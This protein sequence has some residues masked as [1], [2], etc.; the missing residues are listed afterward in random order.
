MSFT[1]EHV[2]AAGQA[3]R[4]H[5]AQQALC[6][7]LHPWISSSLTS[8]DVSASKELT[9]KA[10][11]DSSKQKAES[12]MSTSGEWCVDIRFDIRTSCVDIRFDTA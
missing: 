5:V 2:R 1:S 7:Q 3:S 4:S 12:R 10:E 11:S 8:K 6:S 9:Q